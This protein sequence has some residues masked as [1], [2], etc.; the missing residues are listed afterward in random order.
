MG[1]NLELSIKS[2]MLLVRRNEGGFHSMP[3]FLIAVQY[4]I[5]KDDTI[6]YFL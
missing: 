6:C 4:D 5:C 1:E 3:C 2:E